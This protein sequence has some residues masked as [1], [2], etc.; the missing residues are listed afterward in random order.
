[1]SGRFT[2]VSRPHAAHD[3]GQYGLLL[4]RARIGRSAGVV[5]ALGGAITLV[6]A[7]TAHDG[8][9]YEL[10]AGRVAAR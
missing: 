1:M 6:S 10:V 5:F 8:R 3:Q 2:H 7:L 9:F 4:S